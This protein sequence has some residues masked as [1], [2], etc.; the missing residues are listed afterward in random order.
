VNAPE[1][2]RDGNAHA[3]LLF[4][5]GRV[6]LHAIALHQPPVRIVR[7]PRHARGALVPLEYR[8]RPYPLARALRLFRR[9]GRD[10]GITDGAAAALRSIDSARKG[11]TP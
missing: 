4:R 1:I 7:L 2:L 8:G 3:L 5:E 6:W 10:L 9:A 11:E